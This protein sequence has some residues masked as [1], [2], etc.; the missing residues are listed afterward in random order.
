M[1]GIEFENHTL[2]VESF[3]PSDIDDSPVYFVV[4]GCIH[5]FNKQEG[6]SLFQRHQQ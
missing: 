6:T 3:R 1:E 5:G 2:A 4:Y